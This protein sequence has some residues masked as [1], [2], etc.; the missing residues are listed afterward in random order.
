MQSLAELLI[1]LAAGVLAK[2]VVPAKAQ[3][4]MA[5]TL[6]LGVVGSFLGG[7]FARTPGSEPKLIAAALGA[8]AVSGVYRLTIRRAQKRTEHRAR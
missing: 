8:V 3:G 6:L 1:G 7:A 4:D 2:L 5:A